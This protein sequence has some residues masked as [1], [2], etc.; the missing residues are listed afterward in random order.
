M[1]VTVSEDIRFRP[2]LF[3]ISGTL[4]F[5][6]IGNI[7]YLCVCGGAFTMPSPFGT[8]HDHLPLTE[9]M[10]PFGA[11][12]APRRV[13][14]TQIVRSRI[15]QS[16]NSDQ[17]SMYSLS[18]CTTRLKSRIPLLPL[19]CQRPVMPGLVDILPR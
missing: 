13:I 14:T 11:H 9:S 4:L 5:D 12:M 7:R 3:C 17:F 2:A 16:N 15:L 10:L 6:L 8:P 19:I 1:L 18:S